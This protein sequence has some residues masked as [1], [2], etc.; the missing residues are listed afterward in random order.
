MGIM[1]QRKAALKGF[2]ICDLR[3]TM[4]DVGGLQIG[5]WRLL[6]WVA[7]CMEFSFDK[8]GKVGERAPMLWG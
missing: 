4:D 6:I 1:G 2:F 7:P 3:S 5:D 8:W